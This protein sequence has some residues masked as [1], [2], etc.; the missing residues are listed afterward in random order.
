MPTCNDSNTVQFGMVS[1]KRA[2][3]G[4]EGRDSA[5]TEDNNV[6]EILEEG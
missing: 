6:M 1:S 2:G 4:E 5:D 3:M